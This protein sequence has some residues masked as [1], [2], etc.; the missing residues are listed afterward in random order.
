MTLQV[1]EF[2]P[3][4]YETTDQ[5]PTAKATPPKERGKDPKG[6]EYVEFLA[7]C[8]YTFHLCELDD[9]YG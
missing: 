6:A 8:G 5:P 1:P 4:P 3:P 7:G 9:F 2:A